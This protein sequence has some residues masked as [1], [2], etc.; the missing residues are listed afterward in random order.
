MRATVVVA[1]FD[2]R[3]RLIELLASLERQTLDHDV[4]VV[5]NGSSDGTAGALQ[6]SFPRVEVIRLPENVGFGRAVNLGIRQASTDAI[7]LLN[8]DCRCDSEFVAEITAS[9]DPRA[10]YVMAAG[11]LRDTFNG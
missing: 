5:D 7:V 2:G 9:L 4:I 3:P 11:V 8:N 6:L 1:T 10:G